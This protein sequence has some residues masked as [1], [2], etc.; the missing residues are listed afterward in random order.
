MTYQF[1]VHLANPPADDAARD[2]VV[3][4]VVTVCSG[5]GLGTPTVTVTPFESPG[6]LGACKLDV[7]G[8]APSNADYAASQSRVGLAALASFALLVPHGATCVMGSRWSSSEVLAARLGDP[9]FPI[10]EAHFIV[11]D[12]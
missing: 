10:E 12:A 3:R 11:A 9:T 8:T 1:K 5:M 7:S 4:T 6:G 2:T